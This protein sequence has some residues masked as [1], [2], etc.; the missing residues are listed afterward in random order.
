MPQ[1]YSQTAANKK[2][3]PTFGIVGFELTEASGSSPGEM[4]DVA[5]C[6]VC[7][8][9]TAENEPNHGKA[10]HCTFRALRVMLRQVGTE[11]LDFSTDAA[12]P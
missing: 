3:N 5:G 11:V 12:P 7:A 8:E 6:K 9:G 4:A 1:R 2:G 10:G